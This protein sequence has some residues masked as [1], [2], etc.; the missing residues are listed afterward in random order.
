M[1]K[2]LMLKNVRLSYPKLDEP[3]YFGGTKQKPEDKR[4][5]SAAFHILEGDPQKKMI[6][7]ALEEEAEAKWD[8]KWAGILENILP[9][10]K[11]CCWVNGKRKDVPGVFILNSHRPKSSI[12][13]KI[14]VGKDA[15]GNDVW[16]TTNEVAQGKAGRIYSGMYVN[17]HVEI[18]AQDNKSGKGMR[19]TL[20]GI[21]RFK[22]GDAFSGGVAPDEDAFGEITEGADA[23]D[24]V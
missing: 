8:K 13:K 12:Y 10:P 17:A 6:D 7:L 15:A 1:A 20:I 2:I 24:L 21:Q 3:E 18:W 22:D 19:C 23:D 4:R 16:V 9:D 5:W 11:G 14:T